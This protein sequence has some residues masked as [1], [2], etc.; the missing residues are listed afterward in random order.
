MF[1]LQNYSKKEKGKSTTLK[2]L[3]L[4]GKVKPKLPKCCYKDDRSPIPRI[5]AFRNFHTHVQSSDPKVAAEHL[6][7][8]AGAFERYCGSRAP[9][10]GDDYE[11]T[12][13]GLLKEC[14]SFLM[15]LLGRVPLDPEL[16]GDALFG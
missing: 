5:V 9:M 1:L 15:R 14:V 7:A 6:E 16:P 12:R 11:R 2:G 10:A 3:E 13:L 8:A 4:R